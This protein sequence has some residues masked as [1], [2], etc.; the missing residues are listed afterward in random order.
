M[1]LK[2]HG[3]VPLWLVKKMSELK[4]YPQRFSKVG[5]IYEALRKE[6]NV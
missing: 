4:I 3:A 5:K 2:A 6:K 1:E